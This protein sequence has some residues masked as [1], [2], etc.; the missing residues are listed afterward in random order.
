MI[1]QRRY[2]PRCTWQL[3]AQSGHRLVH[4]KCPLLGVK[5]TAPRRHWCVKR[6]RRDSF[7]CGQRLDVLRPGFEGFA[8]F[9]HVTMP[10]INSRDT[11]ERPTAVVQCQLNNMRS[12]PEPLEAAGEASA[13]IMKRPW[14]DCWR[15]FFLCA[16]M[17]AD[18]PIAAIDHKLARRGQTFRVPG[19]SS[20]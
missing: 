15:D 16:T 19:A 20:A 14:R 1:E 5:R 8:Y 11:T 18:R 2:L 13:K 3:M 10:L 9:S 12:N 17:I 7:L 4:C 6:L